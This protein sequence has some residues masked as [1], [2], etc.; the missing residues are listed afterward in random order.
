[1]TDPRTLAGKVA[2]AVAGIDG[3][4]PATNLAAEISWLPT[5][6]SGGAVDLTATEV[7]VR[8]VALQLPLPPLLALAETAVREAL[9]GTEWADAHVRLVVTELAGSA[10]GS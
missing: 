3:L 7:E 5:D 6:P 1:M 8:L 2:D 9:D 4:R 10:F